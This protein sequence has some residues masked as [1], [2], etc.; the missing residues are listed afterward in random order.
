MSDEKRYPGDEHPDSIYTT[1]DMAEAFVG[2]IVFPIP[3]LVEDGVFE[4]AEH[5][6]TVRVAGWPVFV[7][8]NVAFVV[9]LT[10]ALI[11]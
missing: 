1:R 11:Y 5:F 3:L 6:L 7:L 8:G 9:L 2:S 4:T 10:G